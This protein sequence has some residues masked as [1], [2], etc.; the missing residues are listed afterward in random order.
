AIDPTQRS[1]SAALAPALFLSPRAVRTYVSLAT[2]PATLLAARR[3]PSRWLSLRLNVCY[4]LQPYG[5][6]EILA[7]LI[8]LGEEYLPITGRE[9][10]GHDPCSQPQKSEPS[11][12]PEGRP[13]SWCH[14]VYLASHAPLRELGGSSWATQARWAPARLGL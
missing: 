7:L 8:L 11:P 3:K 4:R 2:A 12:S 13:G 1:C 10:D 5:A 14:A 9:L 6:H